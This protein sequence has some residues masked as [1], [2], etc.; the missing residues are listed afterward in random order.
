MTDVDISDIILSIARQVSKSLTQID[1]HP[2]STGFQGILQKTQNILFSDV[3]LTGEAKIPIVGKVSASTS[4]EASIDFGLGKLTAKLRN[5]PDGRARL[6]QYLDPQIDNLIEL[7]NQELLE[8]A[9]QALKAQGKK[10]LVV[11]VDSL[12]RLQRTKDRNLKWPAKTGQ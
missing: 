1:I 4:G 5:N 12:D 2:D 11:I 6:R 9:N 8:P 3:D 7:V 10:G